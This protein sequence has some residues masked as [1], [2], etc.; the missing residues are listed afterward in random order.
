MPQNLPSKNFYASGVCNGRDGLDPSNPAMN[1]DNIYPASAIANGPVMILGV[2]ITLHFDGAQTVDLQQ[3]FA[4]NS[5]PIGGDIMLMMGPGETRSSVMYPPGYGKLLSPGQHIDYHVACTAFDE[6]GN[7]VST[8]TYQG[9][10]T[11]YY[12]TAQ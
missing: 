9:I 5:D 4:G 6:K 11:V 10:E 3:A 1:P 12:V 7:Y 2:E 8:G